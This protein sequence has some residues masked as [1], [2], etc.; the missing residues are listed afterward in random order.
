ML[1]EARH[2]RIAVVAGSQP[3]VEALLRKAGFEIR[4]VTFTPFDADAAGKVQHFETYNRTAASQKVAD[5]VA[6]LRASP[7][8]IL[9]ANGDAA[10]PA[11]LAAAITPVRKAVVE[12]GGFDT[13]S[14]AQF[15]DRVYIP[16]LRRAGDF[17]TAAGMVRGDVIVHGAGDGF[18]AP[19]IRVDRQVLTA[20][21][22]V[23]LASR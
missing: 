12:V 21:E 15:I 13:S 19:G 5:I 2:A 17:Q 6:A 14:D 4:P 20:R 11:L 1:D 8:A 9:V 23:A 10:L 18:R 16:G 22:I 7:S 3:D